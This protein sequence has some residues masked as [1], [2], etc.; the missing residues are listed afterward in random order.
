MSVFALV[1][2]SVFA[3]LGWAGEEKEGQYV[4]VADDLSSRSIRILR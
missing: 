1:S 3:S 2:V 4:A